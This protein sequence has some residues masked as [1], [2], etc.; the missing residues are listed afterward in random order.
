[1]SDKGGTK[2]TITVEGSLHPVV[3]KIEQGGNYLII[4]PGAAPKVVTAIKRHLEESFAGTDATFVIIG[5]IS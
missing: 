2:H 3:Q 4:L 5:R 1:M